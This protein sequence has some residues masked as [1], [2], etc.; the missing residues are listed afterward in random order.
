MATHTRFRDS[1]RE[2]DLWRSTPVLDELV[3]T[4]GFLSEDTYEFEFV[5]LERDPSLEGFIDFAATPYDGWI[6]EVV[7]F[8]GGLDSLAGTVTESMVGRRRVFLVNHRS[9]EKLL[10]RHEELLH[11]LARHAPDFPAYFTSRPTQQGQA[12]WLVSTR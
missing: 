2:I 6:D 3:S 11:G 12:A 5:P 7:M 4:L 9:N 10:W 1:V 8:S